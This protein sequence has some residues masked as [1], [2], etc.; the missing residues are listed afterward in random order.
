VKRYQHKKGGIYRERTRFYAKADHAGSSRITYPL[1]E[2]IMLITVT[3]PV[4]QGEE[5]VIY[6]SEETG[7]RFARPAWMFDQPERFTPLP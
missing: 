1:E 5:V 7:K 6:Q 2:G 3:D 4:K